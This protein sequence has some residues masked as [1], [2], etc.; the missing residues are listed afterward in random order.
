MGSVKPDWLAQLAPAHAPPPSGFW[1]PAPGWW[2]AAILLAM[3]IA[4]IVYWR[5]RPETRLRRIALREL[6]A[7]ESAVLDD[8][9]LAHQLEH[10]LR[11]Y[12]VA[13]FGR[14]VVAH[15]AGERWIAFIVAH[16]GHAWAEGA[17]ASLL[18]IAYGGTAA[19]DRANWLAGARAFI[20]RGR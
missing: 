18:R 4:V 13:R 3:L 6:G 8:I 10:L 5:R 11:R 1:P 2:V 7:L 19:S 16:G 12:A 20:R 9:E 14:D 17:G 15:L